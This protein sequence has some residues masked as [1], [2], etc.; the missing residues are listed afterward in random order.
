MVINR[1]LRRAIDSNLYISNFIKSAIGFSY[2][3]KMESFTHKISEVDSIAHIDD[4]VEALKEI[5][6]Q[7]MGSTYSLKHS[8]GENTMYGYAEELLNY[9]GLSYKDIFYLP[10]LEHGI[11]VPDFFQSSMKHPYIFEG[12]YKEKLWNENS[13]GVHCYYV[14]PYIYYAK[15]YYEKAELNKEKEKLGKTVLV[16]PP[17]ST[18]VDEEGK[19]TLNQF[20]KYL[21]GSIGKQFDSIIACIFWINLGDPYVEKLRSKGVKVVS[22]GFK[23]DPLFIRRLRTIIDFADTVLYP[24][25]TTSIGYAYH[26]GK[27]VVCFYDKKDK[28]FIDSVAFTE[29]ENDIINSGFEAMQQHF[30]RV[31]SEDAEPF[32]KEQRNLINTYWGLDEIKTPE[33]IRNIVKE[34][35]KRIITHLGF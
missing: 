2:N 1:N 18:E 13:K 26:L 20:D 16:F 19:Y 35:K 14:G 6:N 25:F 4:F 8:Y 28:P 23:L 21:F 24:A 12:R 29:K 11:S 34:N 31:F 33:E 5:P 7:I 27:R 3:K 9:A 30:S 22:A 17:H 10:L 15:D 32:S